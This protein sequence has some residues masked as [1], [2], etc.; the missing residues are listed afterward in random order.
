MGA[1][2]APGAAGEV[3]PLLTG[4]QDG[5]DWVL[6]TEALTRFRLP[7]ARVFE[8]ARPVRAEVRY[9]FRV[10]SLNFLIWPHT[11]SEV[12]AMAPIATIPNSSPWLLGMINLRSNLVPVFDLAMLCALNGTGDPASRWILVLE[13]GDKAVGLIINGVPKQLSQLSPVHHLPSI[14]TILRGAVSAGYMGD[15]VLWLE[16]DHRTFFSA[17][18]DSATSATA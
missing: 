10:G 7:D 18:N 17:L 9:G 8:Q 11:G 2:D 4:G 16:F 3:R 5:G 13:K 1:I 12:I 14:P 6:P 15:D